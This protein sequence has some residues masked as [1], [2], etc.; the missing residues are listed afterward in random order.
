MASTTQ[1]LKKVQSDGMVFYQKLRHFHWN[2]KGDRFF[3]LHE[4]FEEMYNQWA[5]WVDEVAERILQLGDVPVPTLKEAIGASA[6]KETTELPNATG[7]MQM[8]LEDLKTQRSVFI[9]VKEA[10]VEADDVTTEN[11][12]DDMADESAKLIWMF[13]AWL[14]E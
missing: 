2:V 9:K 1:H 13:E 14:A 7:M 8:L 10:A 11:L 4:K 12:M 6:L 5:E 3:M